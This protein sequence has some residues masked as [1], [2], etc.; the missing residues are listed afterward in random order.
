MKTKVQHQPSQLSQRIRIA[1]KVLLPCFI[2][3]AG[4]FITSHFLEGKPPGRTRVGEPPKR[5]VDIAPILFTQQTPSIRVSGE[6]E[7]TLSVNLRSQLR[8]IVTDVNAQLLPGGFVS[9]GEK[10]LNIDSREHELAVLE[11]KANLARQQALFQAE[12]GRRKAAEIEYKLSGRHLSPEQLTLVLRGPQLAQ[13]KAE[14]AK[15]EAL[16]QRAELQLSRTSIY[17]PFDAQIA[18]MTLSK[19]ALLRDNTSLIDLVATDSFYLKVSVPASQL[20][21]I[22]VPKTYT[23]T[24]AGTECLGASVT[25][26]NPNEWQYNQSRKGCVVSQLPNLDSQIKSAS[27]L[28]EIHD[29]LAI[30]PKNAQQPQVLLNAFLQAEIDTKPFDNVV[31]VPRRYLEKGQSIW[32]MDEQH[33]LASRNVSIAFREQ[34][35]VLIDKGLT[36]DEYIVTTPIPG[37]VSGIQLEARNLAQFESHNNQTAANEIGAQGHE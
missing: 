10:L 8:G 36:Q 14:L 2:L 13:I 17:A 24:K 34:D 19:G 22:D 5:A 12:D 30:Q 35:Y 33:K 20:R 6:V 18:D 29:P 21:L 4:V 15:H 23:K 1:L 32:V 11:A 26:K 37:A 25:I 16:L 31:K 28:I 9:K 27:L 7:P 3:I